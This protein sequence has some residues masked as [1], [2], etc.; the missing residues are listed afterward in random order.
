[1][2]ECRQREISSSC[3]N[4]WLPIWWRELT[5]P[6]TEKESSTQK[7]EEQRGGGENVQHVFAETGEVRASQFFVIMFVFNKTNIPRSL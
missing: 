6:E 3:R 4:W 7:E 2:L 5:Q 1:M